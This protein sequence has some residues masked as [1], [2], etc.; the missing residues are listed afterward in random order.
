MSYRS[1][2]P[3]LFALMLL[4]GCSKDSTVTPES[5]SPSGLYFSP[6]HQTVA[7]GQEALLELKLGELADSV[8]AITMQIG[9]DERVITMANSA[10]VTS[11]DFFGSEAVYFAQDSLSVIRLAITRT[12]GQRPVAGS[13]TLA[14]LRLQAQAAGSC[15]LWINSDSLTFY[16]AAGRVLGIPRLDL[17]SA[18][19]TVP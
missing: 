16:D 3:V 5:S 11:G 8:F 17:R 19:I 1:I 2:V 14:S 10:A 6:D 13:G 4:A 12:Q 15:S 18:S 7:A 9:C